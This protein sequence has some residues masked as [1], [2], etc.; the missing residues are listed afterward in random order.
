MKR[1]K[2]PEER[3][4]LPPFIG[5]T[6]ENCNSQANQLFNPTEALIA[7]MKALL[8]QLVRASC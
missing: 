3:C 2:K 7:S 1:S 5:T 8:A 4:C 6:A